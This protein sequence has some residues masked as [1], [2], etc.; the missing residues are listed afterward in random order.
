[1]QSET[2]IFDLHGRKFKPTLAIALENFQPSITLL[3]DRAELDKQKARD[4]HQAQRLEKKRRA[5]L[6]DNIRGALARDYR[7]PS[8]ALQIDD[9]RCFKYVRMLKSGTPRAT[10]EKLMMKALGKE[11][12]LSPTNLKNQTEK[13]DLSL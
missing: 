3:S 13:T 8:A 5:S 4:L 2:G 11:G 10:V 12:K 1:M 7:K 6:T 9:R